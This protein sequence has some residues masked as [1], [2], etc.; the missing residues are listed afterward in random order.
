MNGPGH[1][2]LPHRRPGRATVISIR[3][4]LIFVAVAPVT[5]LCWVLLLR[6]AAVRH[7]AW[8]WVLFVIGFVGTVAVGVL[9][10]TVQENSPWSAAGGAFMLINCAF[11]VSY[12]LYGDIQ[13]QKHLD[14]LDAQHVAAFQNAAH[15]VPPA[16]GYGY[17]HRQPQSHQQPQSQPYGHPAVPR[18][19]PPV[20][21]PV[22]PPAP[23]APHPAPGPAPY[24]WHQAV[25]QPV[26][27]VTQP[28]QP[29]P[30]AHQY[31][32]PQPAQSP[33]PVQPVQ[34]PPPVQ[35]ARAPQ[36]PSGRHRRPEGPPR[37]PHRIDEVRAELDELSD[38]LRK[39]PKDGARGRREE[40]EW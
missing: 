38:L 39:E 12:Y 20:A 28:V 31:Q 34:S 16:G 11:S 7:K 33:Q 14:A 36:P 6:L 15:A 21:P 18:V 10:Q 1:V 26:Q 30:A 29:V 23:R 2:P 3:V 27:A 8:D 22:M 25:T 40:Q 37:T 35:P 19:A 17:P 9:T 4:A 5:L 13:H 32:S 24:G